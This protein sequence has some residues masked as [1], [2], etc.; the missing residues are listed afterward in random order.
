MAK[1]VLLHIGTPK[2]GT[3]SIQHSLVRARMNGDLGQVCYPLLE[4]DSN[5]QRLAV[6]Y[7]NP[8][9]LGRLI[10]SERERY[11]VREKSYKR[12]REQYRELLS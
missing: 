4:G 8:D 6:L 1:S 12:M 7:L 9:E 11:P 10:P 5:Q 2:T 3:T